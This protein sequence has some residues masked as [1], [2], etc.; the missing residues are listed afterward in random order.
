MWMGNQDITCCGKCGCVTRVITCCGMWT[1]NQDITCCIICGYVTT[2]IC[3][4]I[5]GY[6]TT[7]STYC[8]I[9]DLKTRILPAVVYVDGKLVFLPAV[10]YVAV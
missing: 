6:V 7:C 8:G 4:I 3:G 1:G 2:G 9:C 10:V 5:C